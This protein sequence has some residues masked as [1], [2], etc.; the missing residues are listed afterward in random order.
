MKKLTFLLIVILVFCFSSCEK[1]IDIDL[2]Q[3]EEKLIVEGRIEIG[4]GP[5]WLEKPYWWP[6]CRPIYTW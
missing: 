2:P 1:E 5:L 6:T 3:A 4:T